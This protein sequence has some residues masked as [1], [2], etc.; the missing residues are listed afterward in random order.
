MRGPCIAGYLTCVDTRAETPPPTTASPDGRVVAFGPLSI[1]VDDTV[2]QPRPWTYLQSSWGAELLASLPAGDV[3]ELCS[4]AGQIGL[5]A[6]EG[7]G[8]R[9]V[10]VDASGSACA[11]ARRN[12]R[13]VDEVVDVREGWFDAALGDA[14]RFVLVV[15]DPPWVPTQ[16]VTDH[17]ED[18]VLAID[19][20]LDGLEV[21]RRCVKVA[22]HH[23]A[24]DG[25]VLLQ[26]GSRDQVDVLERT[27]VSA[28]LQLEEVR[29][30]G[31]G[32]SRG[33]VALLAP[34]RG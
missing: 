31:E 16:R 24:D 3:L 14:E 11:L 26:L 32:G 10:M 5:G 20:G 19:G 15:A 13:Q 12:A 30:G 4:G 25:R 7:S 8:R 23:L 17:P 29:D 33:V 6:V 22:A 2:L 34:A 18:P 21:A 28:G 1:E 9:L 27:L